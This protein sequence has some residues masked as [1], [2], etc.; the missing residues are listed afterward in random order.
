MYICF[1]ELEYQFVHY[2]RQTIQLW[3]HHGCYQTGVH[4]SDKTVIS[5]CFIKIVYGLA[6]FIEKSIFLSNI[7]ICLNKRFEILYNEY[8]HVL[9]PRFGHGGQT[10]RDMLFLMHKFVCKY[11]CTL[12]I[13]WDSYPTQP[14]GDQAQYRRLTLVC[15]LMHKNMY[16]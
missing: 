7:K 9:L 14:G 5:K 4:L 15:S 10:R 3:L 16:V 2:N 12:A 11:R 1:K 8:N 13:R 6:K